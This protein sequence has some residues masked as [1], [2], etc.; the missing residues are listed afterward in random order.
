MT[1]T[2]TGVAAMRTPAPTGDPAG[3]S[4]GDPAGGASTGL[5]DLAVAW[6]DT[7]ARD[8]PWRHTDV[9]AW[10]VLVSEVM[11]QQTPVARVLPAW[12]RWMARWPTPAA[13]A[14]ASAADAIR[15]WDRLGYPRRA[16]RLYEC[17]GVLT[18]EHGGQ[19]PSDIEILRGLPGVG[20]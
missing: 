6:F 14:D 15:E 7:H 4:A 13:L 3:G 16:L 18:R 12:T 8:L 19:V 1:V 9:G 10:G 2:G 11:L 17:A 5:A 20:T